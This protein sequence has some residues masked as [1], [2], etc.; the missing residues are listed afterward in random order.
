[1]IKDYLKSIPLFKSLTKSE[2]ELLSTSARERIYKKGHI[3]VSEGNKKDF[4]YIIKKGKVKLYKSS[5]DEKSIIL[6]I[7]GANSIL[8]GSTL[9]NDLPNP[10]TIMTIEDCL[11]YVFNVSDI[12]SLVLNNSSLAIDIIEMLGFEL[13]AAQNKIKS[14]ALDDSYTRV[15]KLLLHL[16]EKYGTFISENS[17]ELDL[18]LTRSEM[19]DVIGTSRETVSRILNQLSKEGVINIDEKKISITNKSKLRMWLK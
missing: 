1:M 13:I 4:I 10:S 9:F 19:A 12:E 6:D 2:L 7:K 18:I 15:I 3:V 11:I 14:L 5:S 8:G 17:V 16:S